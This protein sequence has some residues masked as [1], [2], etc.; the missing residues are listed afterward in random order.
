MP[1]ALLSFSIGG[2]VSVAAIYFAFRHVPPALFG[3]SPK[4]AAGFTLMTHAI[5][6]FPV[7]LVGLV[8][9][10][11]TGVNIWKT[12]WPAGAPVSGEKHP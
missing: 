6:L 4:N 7:M 8:S 10:L 5:Q 3:T 9:V 11:I 12:S 2:F 1:K